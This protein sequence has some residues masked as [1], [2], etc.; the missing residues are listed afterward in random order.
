MTIAV[1]EI[2]IVAY[3]EQRAVV[4]GQSV[5]ERFERLDVKVVRR[6]VEHEE[7]RRPREQLG[8]NHAVAFAAG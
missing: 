1:E 8:E 6:L 2:A 3:D 5:L 7:I 4:L